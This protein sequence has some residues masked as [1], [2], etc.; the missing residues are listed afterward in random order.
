VTI[1]PAPAQAGATLITL[2]VNDGNGG[3][4]EAAFFLVVGS[5][6]RAPS[7][8][9]LP[10][11]SVLGGVTSGP[12]PITVSDFESPAGDLVLSAVSSDA[13]LLDSEGIVFGGT[14][15]NR[16]VALTP[17]SGVSGVATLT[18]R[19]TDPDGENSEQDVAAT[20]FGSDAP[21]ILSIAAGSGEVSL[22]FTTVAG[23]MYTVEFQEPLGSPDWMALPAVEG[24]GSPVTVSDIQAGASRFYRVR[25]Q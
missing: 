1:T 15:A 22:T 4:S 16:T 24:T 6:N 5:L 10:N 9:A 11:L 13:S 20:V 23:A 25:S 14:G 7:M 8:S 2:T 12:F 18:L 21:H 3:Q 17:R 19:L